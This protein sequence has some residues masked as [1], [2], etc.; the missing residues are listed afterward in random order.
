M[1][2]LITDM[3]KALCGDERLNNHYQQLNSTVTN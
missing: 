2:K 1:E 3:K